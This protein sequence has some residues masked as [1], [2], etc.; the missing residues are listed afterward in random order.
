MTVP[1]HDGG[2]AASSEPA[3]VPP[4]ADSALDSLRAAVDAL[5]WDERDEPFDAADQATRFEAVHDA[6]VAVLADVDRT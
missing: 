2:R 6:L 5:P 3:D 4:S 1:G